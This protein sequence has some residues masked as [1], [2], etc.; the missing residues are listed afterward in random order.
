MTTQEQTQRD[1]LLKYHTQ[2]ELD[3]LL[4]YHTP[5]QIIFLAQRL[6][7]DE[8]AAF[9]CKH[10]GEHLPK[11]AWVSLIPFLEKIR[12][13]PIVTV[14]IFDQMEDDPYPFPALSIYRNKRG[15]GETDGIVWT[16]EE[17][18]SYH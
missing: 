16:G 13:W 8:A 9:A 11:E 10:Y 15:F 2:E 6:T 12:S 14:G 5:K 4:Q 3:F 1:D 18:T 17:W 7:I